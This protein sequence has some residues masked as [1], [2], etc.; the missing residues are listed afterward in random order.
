MTEICGANVRNILRA[1]FLFPL[2]HAAPENK[3]QKIEIVILSQK[4]KTAPLV[5]TQ[6]RPGFRTT[7]H[8][9]HSNVRN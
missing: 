5:L 6:I 2:C 4:R 7:E 9:F 8:N 1:P 3:Q